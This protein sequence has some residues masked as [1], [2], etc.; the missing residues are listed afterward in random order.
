MEEKLMKELYA[1]KLLLSELRIKDE[2]SQLK[3]D[4]DF[5]EDRNEMIIK[6]RELKHFTFQQIADRLKVSRQRVHQVYSKLIKDAD[7]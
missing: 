1:V 5:T 4:I 6:Y 2:L 3:K 7:L